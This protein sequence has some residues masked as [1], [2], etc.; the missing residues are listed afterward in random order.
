MHRANPPVEIAPVVSEASASSSPSVSSERE[1]NGRLKH[2]SPTSD[3]TSSSADSSW[4][5]LSEIEKDDGIQKH[6]GFQKSDEKETVSW[7]F[8]L[9]KQERAGFCTEFFICFIK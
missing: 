9:H 7:L 8:R 6:N 4:H 2:S 1:K 5:R 3:K